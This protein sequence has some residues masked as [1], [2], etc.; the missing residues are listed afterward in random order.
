MRAQGGSPQS[1]TSVTAPPLLSALLR[2]VFSD[3]GSLALQS[4]PRDHLEQLAA[5]HNICAFTFL[6]SWSPTSLL[7]KWLT[8]R[9]HELIQD[10]L[11]LLAEGSNSIDELATHEVIDACLRRGILSSGVYAN[12]VLQNGTEEDEEDK[13]ADENEDET[14]DTTDQDIVNLLKSNWDEEKEREK[15]RQWISTVSRVD[16][17]LSF[18]QNVS[19]YLH[20]STLG[21][22]KTMDN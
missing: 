18:N 17:L 2:N 22:T 20:S 10:D 21:L 11:L 15:L 3:S 1:L 14:N 19:L 6:Y 16:G 8:A 13:D 12:L 9:G 7:V 4:L 5:S